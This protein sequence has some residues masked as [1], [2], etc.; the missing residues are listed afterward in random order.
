MGIPLVTDK[1]GT[2]VNG[3][4][5]YIPNIYFTPCLRT[6]HMDTSRRRRHIR[7]A[8]GKEEV[9]CFCYVE[10]AGRGA[11]DIRLGCMCLVHYD[12]LVQYIRSQLG[13]R[14]SLLNSMSRD[15]SMDDHQDP[16][17]KSKK[18]I[19]CPFYSPYGNM[20]KFIAPNVGEDL[21][22]NSS[23]SSSS[24][25][26]IDS[27]SFDCSSPRMK[28]EIAARNKYFMDMDDLQRVVQMGSLLEN[29]GLFS[30]FMHQS[31]E[32]VQSTC[33]TTPQRVYSV[34]F[35]T[36]LKS[37]DSS[38]VHTPLSQQEVDKLKVW[39]QEDEQN[40]VDKYL[41]RS[42][43]SKSKQKKAKKKMS[44][45]TTARLNKARSLDFPDRED[46][47][48]NRDSSNTRYFED[49]SKVK[50]T[51]ALFT[52]MGLVKINDG[53]D[54]E[55]GGE[56]EDEEEVEEEHEHKHEDNSSNYTCTIGSTSTDT[57]EDLTSVYIIA[58]TKPCPSCGF[59]ATHY[60][61]HACH[62]ISPAG[63]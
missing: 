62:H 60:H 47:N 53:D 51:K 11:G 59:R 1:A 36:P 27:S 34:S 35:N 38:A 25:S 50:A 28:L 26:S 4:L 19:V 55:D 63:G 56:D 3:Q 17:S 9:E 12:C 54:D 7:Y 10:K 33:T 13:D 22:G 15:E 24:S 46:S 2:V 31:E 30:D 21:I 40:A 37:G 16:Q 8:S 49:E 32:C 20:C 43:Y 14:S 18:G 23:S 41:E 39:I 29:G 44:K 5:C 52:D 6:S 42:F 58:T 57:A 48:S 61:G 45:F